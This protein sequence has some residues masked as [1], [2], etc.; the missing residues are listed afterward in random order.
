M[1]T[2]TALWHTMTT[3]NVYQRI[4]SGDLILGMFFISI[5]S[6]FIYEE[7]RDKRYMLGVYSLIFAGIYYFPLSAY[8]ILRIAIEGDSFF[9]MFWLLPIMIVIPYTLTKL[10]SKLVK[11]YKILFLVGCTVFLVLR[12]ETAYSVMLRS[13][14]I[15]SLPNSVVEV[16]DTINEH[17]VENDIE[18]ENMI[19]PVEF[20]P[21]VRQYD[22]S[23]IMPI[24]GPNRLL[25]RFLDRAN[26]N[27]Q[28]IYEVMENLD[29]SGGTPFVTYLKKEEISYFVL[30][31]YHSAIDFLY[32]GIR[33]I[34]TVEGYAIFHIYDFSMPPTF[35]QGVNYSS[36]FDYHYYI[37]RYDDVVD[38]I[39][40]GYFQVLEHFVTVGMKEGRR[41]NRGFDVHIYMENYP[42]MYE[43]FG[44]YYELWFH[45]YIEYGFDEEKIAN[46]ILPILDDIN[47]D[48]VFRFE[49]FLNR[50]PEL[51]Y[52]LETNEE[53]LRFF[54]E[55]GM[56][57]GLQG[58]PFFDVQFYKERRTDLYEL[59][60]D[61]LRQYFTHFMRYNNR[62]EREHAFDRPS[63]RIRF[64]T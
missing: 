50:Y 25:S 46:R 55:E 35:F 34:G 54:I 19:F 2:I 17:I 44:G 10:E 60:S 45:H 22:A 27:I 40:L 64:R 58:S 7:D 37:M 61:D 29:N 33:K 42:Q 32:G 1:E 11:K 16:V 3:G 39:G 4:Q 41:G 23:I 57:L 26:D 56:E 5:V 52:G 8:V 51:T 62:M 47:Y 24:G 63:N 14:N 28:A 6:I 31:E 53:V 43:Y 13:E 38:S 49:Y 30:W 36:V 21:F 20:L 59:Y 15:Y 48:S 9:R 12:G 18:V